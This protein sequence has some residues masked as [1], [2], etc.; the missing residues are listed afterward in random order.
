ML[1]FVFTHNP[2]NPNN[3]TIVKG[4]L[5]IQ[6]QLETLKGLIPEDD[7]IASKRKPKI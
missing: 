3:N 2:R 7:T 6:H 4:N 5:P 1:L